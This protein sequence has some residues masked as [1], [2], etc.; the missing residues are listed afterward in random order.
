MTL[1]YNLKWTMIAT[2]EKW[3]WQILFTLKKQYENPNL[4]HKMGTVDK[5]TTGKETDLGEH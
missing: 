2:Y 4:T 5:G 1:S 3:K